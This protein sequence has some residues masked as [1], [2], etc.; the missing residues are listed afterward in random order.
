M[1]LTARQ[2]MLV[3]KLME[4]CKIDPSI[5]HEYAEI[6]DIFLIEREGKRKEET[7]NG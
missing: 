6:M 1:E 7:D 5:M 4:D 2:C 3:C